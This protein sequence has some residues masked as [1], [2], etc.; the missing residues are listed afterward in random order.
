MTTLL[1]PEVLAQVFGW[2][3]FIDRVRVACVS[4]YWRSSALEFPALWAE[5]RLLDGRRKQSF[6][7]L[8]E[9]ALSRSGRHPVSLECGA[10][11]TV[12]IVRD[13][14]DHIREILWVGSNMDCFTSPAPML[15]SF[16]CA[17]IIPFP[18]NFMGSR[19]GALRGL[20]L[21]ALFLPPICP[22][23]A[24]VTHVCT[25]TENV[26]LAPT[27]DRLWKLCPRLEALYMRDLPT[28][29]LSATTP[30]PATLTTLDL[31]ASSPEC[32]PAPFVQA[33]ASPSLKSVRIVLPMEASRTLTPLLRG[34]V[35]IAVEPGHPLRQGPVKSVA[36][37][38]P[39]GCR[40]EMFF[41]DADDGHRSSITVDR[42][43]EAHS[44]CPN[45]REL[46][47]P[48]LV[49]HLSI[50]KRPVLP[51]LERLRIIVQQEPG[52]ARQFD[53]TRIYSLSF[54][55]H[56]AVATVIFDVRYHVPPAD[57]LEDARTL[58]SHVLQH[59][60]ASSDAVPDR[61]FVIRGFPE[62][63][64]ASLDVKCSDGG[65]RITFECGDE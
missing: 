57:A 45:L 28:V 18:P 33:C 3:P 35:E 2:L 32:D 64:L 62:E 43:L 49:F 27:L 8:T 14:L 22:A 39:H 54:L 53:W 36:A 20:E 19:V 25:D 60:K 10:D 47:L 7:H 48:L 41:T 40:F 61:N 55:R 21:R 51:A 52:G 44:H 24:S 59:T 50:R 13:H 23:L 42:L 30:A 16:R 58:V 26:D 38:L 46:A 63:V 15:E 17:R 31:T 65:P 1:P 5:V 6:V 11:S 12:H 4:R 29:P 9:L 34:A 37:L 56:Y